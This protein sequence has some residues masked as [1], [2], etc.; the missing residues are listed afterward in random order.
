MSGCAGTLRHSLALVFLVLLY[1][2]SSSVHFNPN[3]P[4]HTLPVASPPLCT[5]RTRLPSALS[6]VPWVSC[7]VCLPADIRP[8]HSSQRHRRARSRLTRHR[9]GLRL[10]SARH[11][12][13]CP[14]HDRRDWCAHTVARCAHHARFTPSRPECRSSAEPGRHV[15]PLL[16]PASPLRGAAR[17]Y[18]Y[19]LCT[20]A[21]AHVHPRQPG[22]GRPAPRCILANV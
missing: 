16:Q 7:G 13:S 2:Q 15:Q 20:P 10:F 5:A 17:S 3:S 12:P 14:N 21:P 18:P 4:H 1:S 11:L 9:L 8:P 22:R 6:T 19:R